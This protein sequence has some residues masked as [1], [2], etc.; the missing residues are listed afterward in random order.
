MELT[1]GWTDNEDL[2]NIFLPLV[3]CLWLT[4]ALSPTPALS[5]LY[6]GLGL[7]PM[8]GKS[9]FEPQFPHM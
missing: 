3:R 6:H 8:G 4:E 1:A 5:G 9:S 2:H 7:S